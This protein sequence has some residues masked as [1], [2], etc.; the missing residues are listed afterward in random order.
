VN[1]L[2]DFAEIDYLKELVAKHLVISSM[3][4]YFDFVYLIDKFSAGWAIFHL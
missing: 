2:S 4:I 1:L 3:R